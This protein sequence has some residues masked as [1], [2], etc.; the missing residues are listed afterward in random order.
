MRRLI[1]VISLLALMVVFVGA[2][3]AQSGQA[4][5]IV[6]PGDTLSRIAQRF[7][8]S[9]WDLAAVNHI[10][11]PN[12]I[13]VGQQLIIPAPGY[14]PPQ[15]PPPQPP[16]YHPPHQGAY[17]TVTYGDTMASIAARFGV[18][19]QALSS[20]NGIYNPNYIYVGQRLTIPSHGYYPPPQPPPHQPGCIYYTVRRG[21]TLSGIARY[22]GTTV[23]ALAD[24]NG[25]YYTGL[26]YAGQQLCIPTG[27]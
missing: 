25:I 2:A 17:Y 24:A 16:P 10:P 7:G 13:Y 15:Q 3:S 9:L 19:I 18:T 23:W 11:N 26:I 1:I 21:D 22:Y 27:W 12:H 4:Y 6:A 20:A 8:V 14:Y 5:Y